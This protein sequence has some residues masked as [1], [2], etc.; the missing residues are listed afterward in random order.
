MWTKANVD[1]AMTAHDR[2]LMVLNLDI[3]DFIIT[4]LIITESLA[5]TDFISE[6]P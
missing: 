2:V 6:S 4:D 5:A 3:T 1:S